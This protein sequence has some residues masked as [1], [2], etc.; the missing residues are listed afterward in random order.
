MRG[1]LNQAKV[2]IRCKDHF[3]EPWQGLY[4]PGIR[5]HPDGYASFLPAVREII[6]NLAIDE[7]RNCPVPWLVL[8]KTELTEHFH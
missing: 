1:N 5:S 4:L 8:A 6:S 2:V 3:A 7:P